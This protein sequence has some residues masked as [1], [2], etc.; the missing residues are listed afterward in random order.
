MHTLL[1]EIGTEEIPAGYIEPA[2]KALA[3]LLSQKLRAARIEHGNVQTLATPRRLA[4]LVE[5]VAPKQTSLTTE[6]I[7]PPRKGGYDAQGQPTMAAVKFAEKVGVGVTSLKIKET[8]K[9]AYLCAVNKER[10]RATPTI[11]KKI[12][13]EVIPALPFPKSMRWGTLAIEFARPIQ[14][15]LALHGGKAVSFEL[16]GIRSGRQTFGHRFLHPGKIKLASPA[17]YVETLRSASVLVDPAERQ[18]RIK[19]DIAD[20]AQA[21][22]GKVWPD[23][24]LV[25]IVNN[26]VEYPAVAVGK[27]DAQF[28][29]LPDE[30]LITAMREH[31]KY[32]A[33]ADNSDNL[34]PYFIA[35]NNTPAK[36]MAVVARGHERVLRARLEDAK[37]FYTKDL[38]VSLDQQVEK[39]KKVL[40]QAQL[41]SLFD[42]TTR[43]RQI[44]GYIVDRL[45]HETGLEQQVDRAARL[46]KADLVTQMVIEFPKLQGIMGRV[47]AR[48]QGDSSAVATAIEEHYRPVYS[49]AP[50][51]ETLPGA[52]IGIADKI[53]SICGCFSAGLIPTG[54]TDPYALRR[55]GIGIIQIMR[56]NGFTF[57]LSELIAQSLSLFNTPPMPNVEVTADNVGTFLQNRMAYLL[58]EDGYSKD[59]IAAVI[60][61][62]P[63][64][65]P[66]AWRRVQAL[67]KLKAK[68]DFEPLAVAFK[69][70][71]NIIKKVDDFHLEKID[72]TLFEHGSEPA[73]WAACRA[74]EKQVEEDLRQGWFDQALVNIATLRKPVDDFFDDVMVM[75]EDMQVRRN[76]LSLL[77]HIAALFEKVADFSKIAT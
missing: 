17:A 23:E 8:E 77:G 11:L 14:S 58:A 38:E 3:A 13:P 12:L 32:F 47:Y 46:C 65:I 54:A 30:V 67:E 40:F 36:D 5:N 9:G 48:A 35:V 27:F 19:K 25:D 24:E 34:M 50:L 28:L 6:V 29:Q 41:G 62:A 66:D 18:E 68:P 61:V 74:V 71:V 22:G 76:R 33:V 45:D 4:A 15:I 16:G 63:D 59:T 72:Q 52:I 26:L 55:Q 60:S 20:A 42:K 56:A 69:R 75:T 1:V 37:F 70:V 7:G 2:L 10:G 31:Q 51:P 57:L 49:G 39:L 64:N 43:I 21:L 73:L 53:D 44:A